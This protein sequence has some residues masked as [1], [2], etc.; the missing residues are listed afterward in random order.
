MSDYESMPKP[1]GHCDECGEPVWDTR[2]L[3]T[4]DECLDAADEA[5]ERGRQLRIN[6]ARNASTQ[7]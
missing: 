6:Q 2:Q 5:I 7:E 1:A 4:C 3:P